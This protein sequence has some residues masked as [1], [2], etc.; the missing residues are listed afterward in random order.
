MEPLEHI[1]DVVDLRPETYGRTG[2]LNTICFKDNDYYLTWDNDTQEFGFET[3]YVTKEFAEKNLYIQ[4]KHIN[5]NR[6][7]SRK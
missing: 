2:E 4:K 3:H 1:F 5:S 7:F 6:N